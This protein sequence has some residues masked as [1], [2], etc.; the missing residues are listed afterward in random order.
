MPDKSSSSSSSGG[1]GPS[2]TSYTVTSSGTNSQG[3]H[4]CSRDY[5]SS[6]SN[7][8]SYHYSNTDGSYYYSNPNGSTYHNDGQGSSTYTPPGGNAT[9]VRRPLQSKPKQ[10]PFLKR[11]SSSFS[12]HARRKPGSSEPGA[13]RAKVH[14]DSDDDENDPSLHHGPLVTTLARP[15]ASQDVLSLMRYVK[16]QMFAD[17]PERSAGMNS[18][19]IAEVLNFRKTLAPIISI[20]HLQALSESSTATDREIAT[21]VQNGT[22]RRVS[23]VGRGRGGA[24]VGEGV[25]MV[26]DWE[27]LVQ[28]SGLDEQLQAKYLSLLRSH[29]FSSFVD[30]KDFTVVE[31]SQLVSYG[32][33]TSTSALASSTDTVSRAGAFSL[34]I[35][36]PVS[37]A[38]TTAPTG[39]HD[40]VGGIGAVHM[41][42]GG[43]GGLPTG[44]DNNR[45]N[46][47]LTFAIPGTG[48]Y[49]RL[50]SEALLTET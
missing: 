17:I 13:K 44:K 46:G 48:A 29:S 37:A 21:L 40:A 4:Y 28:Q 34:G 2:G 41:R 24:P 32:F 6:A 18:V 33:M 15:D 35:T 27:S 43:A 7:S 9:G 26:T 12:N 11:S 1:S 19:R 31:V 23:V 47:H 39:S 25:V 36:T 42:G 3:N 30:A 20:A 10:N 8:N 49:L 5:G 38:V 14:D 16:D 45:A 22:L 50:V